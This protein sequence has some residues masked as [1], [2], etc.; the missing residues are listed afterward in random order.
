[1]ENAN[2]K[3]TNRIYENVAPNWEPKLTSKRGVEIAAFGRKRQR[4]WCSSQTVH[5]VA[6]SMMLGREK[7]VSMVTGLY[8]SNLLWR[9]VDAVLDSAWFLDPVL[10]PPKIALVD[11]SS[12]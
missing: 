9:Y 1:M 10:G 6:I 12:A 5:F 3:E 7:A 4:A 11:C 8:I 2:K